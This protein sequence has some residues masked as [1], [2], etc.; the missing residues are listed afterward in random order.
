MLG[1]R[2]KEITPG[3]PTIVIPLSGESFGLLCAF[4]QDSQA[5]SVR[6]LRRALTLFL[7]VV[8]ALGLTSGIFETTFNN[9]LNDSFRIT[10]E[11][12]GKLE[13]PRELP[14]FLVA[15][16][17]G[18]LFFLSEIRLGTFAAMA[19]SLGIVGLATMGTHWG[20]M[21]AAMVLWSAG[22][23]MMM[24]VNNTIA[25]SLAPPNRRAARLGQIGSVGMGAT[26]LGSGLVWLGLEYL[27][28]SYRATFTIAA[29]AA[30][31]AAIFVSR[32]PPPLARGKN[33]PKLVLK[34]RYSLYYLL[35]VFSGA[36]KQVF[37]TFGPWV[38]IKVFGEPAPTI[39]KLWIVASTVG[40]FFQ[41]ALG[42]VIDRWGERRVLMLDAVLLVGI[43]LGYGFAPALP[44]A[45]PVHLVY[46]CYVLDNILFAVGMAR[47]TYVDKIAENEA[48]IHAS[49]SV[50]VSIDHAV[51]MS[52][53][54]VGGFLWV[55]YGF[56]YVFVAAAV[57]A[58]CNLMAASFVRVPGR[59]AELEMLPAAEVTGP[60]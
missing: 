15:L 57:L 29:C 18:A 13:F 26:I 33:R 30:L 25:L 36:R 47:A 22:N 58:V 39:A 6:D 12:R 45:R 38:L 48:D 50:G 43:C 49:L 56:P 37:V 1:H 59:C 32:I 10:A 40:I 16:M 3:R 20:P 27:H 52:V 23:H 19:T 4:M 46:V 2:V 14:G 17:G 8:A 7:V 60:D 35:C 53:P 28:F 44:L 54:T 42:R 51:S 5:G 24:P 55:R 41:P 31:V 9:F 21:M 34:R 11:S